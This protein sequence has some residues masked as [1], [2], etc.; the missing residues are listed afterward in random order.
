MKN[1]LL[2]FT[3]IILSHNPSFSQ[4]GLLQFSKSYFRSDPFSGNFSGFMKHLLNDPAIINKQ[5]LYRT[6]TS[7]FYFFGAYKNYNPFFFKPRQIEVRLLESPIQY[8]D[9]LPTDTILVYQLTAYA[10]PGDVGK[11]E[12]KREFEK[13]HRQIN[14]KFY[15]SS[16]KDL[17]SGT[18]ITG[19]VHNYF[20][21]FA[22]LA[23]VSILW[24][25][26]D[27]TNEPV[28]NIILRMKTSSNQAVLA[29][30]LDNP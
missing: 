19:G 17:K 23:P 15:T 12:V 7:L 4:D 21:G 24:A 26:L 5:V 3:L 28:L 13:I 16:Y 18:S 27:E 14:K 22:S 30:S 20:V 9:S 29:T 2:L 10:E 1:F 11:Q 25:I 6:D 8:A